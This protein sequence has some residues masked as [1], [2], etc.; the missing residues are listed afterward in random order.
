[1]HRQETISTTWIYNNKR[2]SDL[3]IYGVET[4]V[5][6][7]GAVERILGWCICTASGRW[8]LSTD[9]D[10][11]EGVL[12]SRCVCYCRKAILVWP[13]SLCMSYDEIRATR[14]CDSIPNGRNYYKDCLRIYVTTGR[15]DAVDS[16]L[17]FGS[18]GREF[19]PRSP[20]FFTLQGI[21]L[22]QVEVTAEVPINVGD[23]LVSPSFA[24]C[25]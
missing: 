16:T 2:Q 12:K 18:T 25:A 5:G 7:H 3:Y 4:C 10:E 13:S 14:L 17:T 21:S 23:N 15:C 6:S 1:M 20:L 22:Q 9:E 19:E 11:G 24:R 8:S